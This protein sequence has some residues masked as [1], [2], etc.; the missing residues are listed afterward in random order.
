[1]QMNN[2]RAVRIDAAEQSDLP[3]IFALLTKCGLPK[4]GLADHLH[5]TFVA[6]ERRRIVGCSALELFEDCALLRSVAVEPSFREQGLG[7]RLTKAALD[8]AKVHQA[9]TVY[10]LTTTTGKFFLKTGFKSVSRSEV[11]EKVRR[12]I[13]FTTLC[14]DTAIAMTA[15]LT[16]EV[17]A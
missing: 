12:S 17:S 7:L 1:M 4:D 9:V 15:S 2:S 5:T 3:A 10:L 13:Q 6:R 11:P 14:P 8:E 16:E